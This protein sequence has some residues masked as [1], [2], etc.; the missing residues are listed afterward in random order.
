MCEVNLKKFKIFLLLIFVMCFVTGCSNDNESA[1]S[2]ALA[3]VERLSD[4]DYEG[5]GELFYQDEDVYFDEKVFQK[6]IEDKKLNIS[7]NK[8]MEV[9]E[10]GSEIT[11]E[12]GYVQSRVKI[13]IDEDRTFNLDTIE[14]DGKWYVYDESFYD[15]GIVVVVPDGAT[16]KLNGNEVDK[17]YYI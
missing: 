12:D 1:E 7:G 2:V 9:T 16:L 17:S 13:L 11:N 14:V 8:T 4:D 10:I 5:I 15:N 3:M 6:L